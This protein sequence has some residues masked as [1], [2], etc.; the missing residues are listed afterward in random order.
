MKHHRIGKL[1][2]LS[3]A[4]QVLDFI[5]LLTYSSISQICFRTYSYAI[6]QVKYFL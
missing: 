4:L 1:G 3:P 2:E 6:N 5:H